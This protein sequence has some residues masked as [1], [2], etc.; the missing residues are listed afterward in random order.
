MKRNLLF[1]MSAVVMLFTACSKYRYEEVKG[2]PLKSR[3]Y[4]LDNGL[5]VYMTVNK[6]LPRIQTYIAVRVG[7]KNDP[8]ETTGLAHYFEH[9]MFKGTEKFGTQNYAEEKPLLDEIERLFEIYRVTEDPAERKALYAQIDSV[10]QLAS[11]FSIPNEYDKLMAAIGASG[12]NAWTSQDETVY[13]EDIPS[14]QIE[15]WAKIQSDRFMN[16]VIRGFHTELETVYEEYNMSLTDDGSKAYYGIMEL[17]FPN[18]PYGQHTVLGYADHLKN[19][20]VTNI[21]NYY[22]T[23]YVPNNMAICLSGDFDPEE[24]I[25]VIDKYFGVMQPNENLPKFEIPA[26]EPITSPKLKEVYGLE[27]PFLYLGWP[28]EGDATSADA[29]MV[30]LV[31]SLLSNGKCGLIDVDLDQQ[32]KLLYSGAFDVVNS[33]HGALV[34][35]GYPK[36]G[37]SLEEVKALLMA[38]VEKLCKG[39][40]DEGLLK[41]T[42]ANYKRGQ[43]RRME[44]NNGRAMAFVNSFINGSEWADEVAALDRM[45]KI[46]KEQLVAWAN[47][48]LK[49]E[50]YVELRKLQGEDLSQVKIEKPT[51]TPISANR[52]A[53]SDFLAEVKA[54]EVKPIEPVFYD[55]ERDLTK[56]S[57]KQ[58]LEVLYKKNE[59]NNLFSLYYVYDFGALTDP[60]LQYALGSYFSL[61]GTD[62]KS[63]EEIQRAFYDLACDFSLSVTDTR[64][65]LS[66][67]GLSENMEAAVALAEEYLQNVE[68]DEAV[69]AELKRDM[70]KER[71]DSKFSQEANYSALRQY[72]YYGPEKIR[73]T[74]LTN[75]Q[76]MALT[77]EELLEKVK[78]LSGIRHRVLYYGPMGEKEVIEKLN[79]LHRVDEELKSVERKEYPFRKTPKSEVF[80][81]QYDA[82][83]I[84]YMQFTNLERPTD[85]KH[86]ALVQ[87]YN[88]YFGG[89][90][91][92]IVFQEMR[93]ARALAYS[94]YAYLSEG[95][96]MGDPYLYYAFIATQN[97]KMRTAIEAFDEIIN[98]M[99]ESEAAFELAKRGILGTIASTRPTK[100][101]ILWLYLAAL[102]KGTFSNRDQAIYEQVQHLTLADIVAFQQEWIQDRPYVY[103]VLGDKNDIDLNYLRTLG[104]VKELSQEEIFGY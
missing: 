68:G 95:R 44:S 53:V 70:L 84:Y 63:L 7:A 90:M 73:A 74:T 10:S 64:V 40:F 32:Q 28:I 61:L 66:I 89:G 72:V 36:Q 26:E 17:L 9:L 47:K 78:A 93:E 48:T 15:N 60:T 51:I 23:Y 77:S 16:N 25:A 59:T 56:L 18:H 38:E 19:P 6:D 21:K 91:N 34:L 80:L 24:M 81:A 101:D 98:Q 99:P 76:L 1:L 13:T 37:Q 79:T 67:S 20:S 33:D 96:K 5:K 45:G 71:A 2:D 39:E 103:C 35:A 14:N 69:L 85:E 97:D 43:M 83:Q 102:D 75:E 62:T 54:S 104:P 87:L 11:K 50:G 57:M 52:D 4:T 3:I 41:S 92:A 94:S 31:S 30:Q 12:T 29:E 58:D 88:D 49:P 46:T 65:Y 55:F 27:A 8:I 82:K 100:G 22:R 86:D 42:I